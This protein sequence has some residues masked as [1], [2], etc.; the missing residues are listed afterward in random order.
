MVRKA[1]DQLTSSA[2]SF[3]STYALGR[4]AD[5]YYAGG[6]RMGTAELKALF[7]SSASSA[8][9]MHAR[10]LPRIQEKAAGLDLRGILA[11]AR[12]DARTAP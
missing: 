3:A 10:Y 11:E 7:E 9:E 5:I 12:G 8:K 2:F 6:R 1:A 4:V